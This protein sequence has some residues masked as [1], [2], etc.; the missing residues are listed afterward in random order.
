MRPTSWFLTLTL[1][2]VATLPL[3]AAGPRRR[4]YAPATASAAGA[5]EGSA[6]GIHAGG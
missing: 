5:R 1:A 3:V 4:L 2:V 6:S